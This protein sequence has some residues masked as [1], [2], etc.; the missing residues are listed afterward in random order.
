MTERDTPSG[1]RGA[2]PDRPFGR[3]PELVHRSGIRR[4]IAVVA[5]AALLLGAVVGGGVYFEWLASPGPPA[6][7]GGCATGVTLWGEGASF[8]APLESAWNS[9]YRAASGNQVNYDEAGA[10]AGISALAVPSVDFAAT[11][12]PLTSAQYHSMRGTV[13]TLPVT[14]GALA[15]VYNLPGL[16]GPIRLNGTVLAQIYFGTLSNWDSSATRAL[17]PGVSFPAQTIVT[18]HRSDA[19]GTTFVLTNYLSE[20]SAVWSDGPGTGIQPSWPSAAAQQAEQGN[21]KVVEYVERTPYSIGYADLPD[22]L[23]VPGLQYAEMQN[24]SGNFLLPTLLDTASAVSDVLGNTSFPTASSPWTNVSLV[25]APG[26]SDY[27]LA[28]FAYLLVFQDARLGFQPSLEKTRALVE[29][30]GFVVGGG[31]NDSAA[32]QYVPLPPALVALDRTAI[33]TITYGGGP[34]SC[35]VR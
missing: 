1:R 5:P 2:L 27:P 9:G 35:G 33:A 3:A 4:W 7:A 31:Q 21:A 34:V 24:P 11:D 14:A 19:A 12:E 25:N 20:A 13:L 6:G 16:S 18:V 30:L 23:G 8:L 10:G 22:V 32:L 29:W 17:N 15:I 28:T 26:P